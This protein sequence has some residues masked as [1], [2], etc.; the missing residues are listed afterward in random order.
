MSSRGIAINIVLYQ[1]AWL[2]SVLG[3]A[4]GRG[5]LCVAGV[6]TALLWHLLRAHEPLR[7]V[8]LIAIAVAIGAAVESLLVASG[9]VHMEG[10][11]L[12][13]GFLPLWMVALWAA[14]ATTLNVSLRAFRNRYALA[15]IL[16]FIGAP[17]AYIAGARL[18]ALEWVLAVPALALIAL[19]WSVSL[20]LL[21]HTA[22]RHD[23]YS[24]T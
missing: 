12:V 22:Q 23:G 11:L 2:A 14:F 18:G 4:T 8:R 16:A 9:W 24:P 3:A 10:R 1:C 7:E 15:S 19:S 17:L 20:P 13:G 21:L 6:C 5:W